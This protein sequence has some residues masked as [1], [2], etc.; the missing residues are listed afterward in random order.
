MLNAEPKFTLS[1]TWLWQAFHELSSRRHR[2]LG[3][4]PILHSEIIAYCKLNEFAG[5][6]RYVLYYCVMEMDKTF[7]TWADSQRQSD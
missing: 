3:A 4:Q 7:M 6:D 2:G 5:D 1:N